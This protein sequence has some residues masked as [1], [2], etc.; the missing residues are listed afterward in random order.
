MAFVFQHKYLNLLYSPKAT[1]IRLV[2]KLYP[3]HMYW[4]DVDIMITLKSYFKSALNNAYVVIS[5]ML[6]SNYM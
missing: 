6:I 5:L 3:H 1:K 4:I 2:R